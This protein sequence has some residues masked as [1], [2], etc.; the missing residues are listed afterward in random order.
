MRLKDRPV[1]V[2]QLTHC[3]SHKERRKKHTKTSLKSTCC[4]FFL[5]IIASSQLPEYA[6]FTAPSSTQK[7]L[8]FSTL[9]SYSWPNYVSGK[10]T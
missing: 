6:F 3:S 9:G 4:L 8:C 5:K 2:D 10:F 1:G 7:G